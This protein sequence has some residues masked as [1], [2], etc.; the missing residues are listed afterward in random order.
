MR[1]R[2]DPKA[3]RRKLDGNQTALAS[4]SGKPPSRLWA[5]TKLRDISA[6]R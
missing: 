5:N 3:M 6:A 1:V 4:A 2:A